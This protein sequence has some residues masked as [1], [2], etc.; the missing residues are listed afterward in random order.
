MAMADEQFYSPN[1]PAETRDLAKPRELAW[2]VHCDQVT[3][4]A[5]LLFHGESWGWE[6]QISRDGELVIGRRFD[7]RKLAV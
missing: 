7:T 2:E 5:D 3:W 1:Y 4:R 6:A